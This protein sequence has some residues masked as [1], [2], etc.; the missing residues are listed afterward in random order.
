MLEESVSIDKENERY[1]SPAVPRSKKASAGL[2]GG[3]RNFNSITTPLA[4]K[5]LGGIVVV[6]ITHA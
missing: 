1:N 3:K 5:T 4:K 6:L 2:A